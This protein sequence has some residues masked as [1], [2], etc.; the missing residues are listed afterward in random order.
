M[1]NRVQVEQLAQWKQTRSHS[2]K[3][4]PLYES[5]K[6]KLCLGHSLVFCAFTVNKEDFLLMPHSIKLILGK[7]IQ[8]KWLPS[9]EL[10]FF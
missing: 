7:L 1:L 4:L 10:K 8:K 2:L 6:E 3:V 9:K 5:K